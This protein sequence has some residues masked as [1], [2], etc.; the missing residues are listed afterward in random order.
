[1]RRNEKIKF[2]EDWSKEIAGVSNAVL[3]DYR[4]LSVAQDTNLRRR[5]RESGS[6][7]RVIKNNLARRAVPG[8]SLEGLT[9][10]F[11]GPCALA[12]NDHDPVVLAKV[13]VDFAKDNEVLEI[14]AGVIDGQVIKPHEVEQLSK[15]PG[16]EELLTKLA[17]V[18]SAPIQGLASALKNIIRNLASVLGQV[19]ANKEG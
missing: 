7:Y 3:V 1:M 4:G 6:S 14:K 18:L 11:E 9:E 19:A 15:T 10:L 13:L 12:Y 16:R 2:V 17:Y 5:I 8:T